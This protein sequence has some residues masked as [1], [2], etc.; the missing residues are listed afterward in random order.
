MAY[1]GRGGGRGGYG[2]AHYVTNVP[3]VP[4]PVSLHFYS[5][6]LARSCQATINS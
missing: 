6:G 4:F 2:H 3:F 5:F 1:R